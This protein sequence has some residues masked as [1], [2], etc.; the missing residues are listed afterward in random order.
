MEPAFASSVGAIGALPVALPLQAIYDTGV[1]AAIRSSGTMKFGE[2]IREL[3]QSKGWTLRDLAPKV[4][5]GFTYICKVE[6]EKLDFGDYP[7]DAL[8]HRLADALDADEEELLI[9]A[10]KIPEPIRRRVLERPDA[11]RILAALDDKTLDRLMEQIGRER[12]TTK[13]RPHRR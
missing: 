13:V 2:R 12:R 11:F 8:I 1:R 5:V 7:S 4:G 10:D 6:N 3:R 9:L